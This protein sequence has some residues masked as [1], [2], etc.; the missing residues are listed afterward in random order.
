LN[1]QRF[2]WRSSFLLTAVAVV[3][4]PAGSSLADGKQQD[5]AEPAEQVDESSANFKKTGR[6][7]PGEEVVTTTGKKMRVWSTEGPVPV[8][9]P[10]EPFED[11]EKSVLHNSHIIV[12]TEASEAE[13]TRP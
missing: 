9:R 1:Q 3:F 2:W 12:D 6:F 13:K 5:A 4:F 8:S 7:L 11:R 10:P